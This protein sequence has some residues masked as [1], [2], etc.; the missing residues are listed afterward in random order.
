VVRLRVIEQKENEWCAAGDEPKD[1]E[2]PALETLTA[3]DG[4]RDSLNKIKERCVYYTILIMVLEDLKDKTN[5]INTLVPIGYWATLI[6]SDN[7]ALNFNFI[8]LFLG[9]L[10]A[11]IQMHYQERLENWYKK[12]SGK[13]SIS[14]EEFPSVAPTIKQNKYLLYS[15]IA[16]LI[17]GL[18]TFI[19]MCIGIK[20]EIV[21]TLIA[22]YLIGTLY[23]IFK[24]V[25]LVKYNFREVFMVG[26]EMMKK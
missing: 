15:G 21:W 6:D 5:L 25:Y 12:L 7:F 22:L 8:M 10:L 9:V 11:A 19:F 26:L 16:I 4:W 1:R 17:Y 13:K 20:S 18:V 23:I 14:I 24:I 2:N 3:R